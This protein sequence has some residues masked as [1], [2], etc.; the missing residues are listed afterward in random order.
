[1]PYG[2]TCGGQRTTFR[3][4]FSPSTGGIPGIELRSSGLCGRT[5]AYLAILPGLHLGFYFLFL[6][7]RIFPGAGSARLVDLL[8]SPPGLECATLHVGAGDQS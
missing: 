5:F 8:A 2:C 4:Q 7:D 6:C 1:M 3:S